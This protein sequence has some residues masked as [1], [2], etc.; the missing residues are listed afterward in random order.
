MP[1]IFSVSS[2]QIKNLALKTYVLFLTLL[3]SILLIAG[4]ARS[5]INKNQIIYGNWDS[6][7]TERFYQ[8]E[9][10]INWGELSYKRLFFFFDMHPSYYA[11][12]SIIAIIILLFTQTIKLK[13]LL[14]WSF[15]LIHVIM[16]IFL[17][18]K[19]GIISLFIVLL[20]Y[21]FIGQSNKNRL[22]GVSAILL[23][24]LIIAKTPSTE[25][26][27][28]NAYRSFSSEQNP[29]KINSTSERLLL[30]NSIADLNLKE[31]FIGA[32][33]SGGRDR[34]MKSTGID[35]N[36][37]NQ[38]LQSLLNAGFIGF[39]LT[40]VFVLLPLFFKRNIF[41]VSLVLI[42]FLNLLFENMLDRI[43]GITAISFFYA[44]IIFGST[45]MLNFNSA[46]D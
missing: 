41:T 25:I 21:L 29:L 37:H 26:R 27:L 22:I 11:L 10:I 39:S 18:S 16:I 3:S 14:K 46:K 34:I 13:K 35:K 36:M 2:E 12:F 20:A 33:N 19:T 42:V 45:E 1:I 30:W 43:W 23:L 40:T 44:F 31:L 7:T 15:I 24:A 38:F 28:K 32:G 6:E 9:M 4:L 17:S 5:V 8:N